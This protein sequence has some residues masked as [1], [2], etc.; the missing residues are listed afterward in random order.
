MRK[1]VKFSPPGTTF[2]AEVALLECKTGRDG[3]GRQMVHNYDEMFFFREQVESRERRRNDA[4]YTTKGHV[5]KVA[6]STMTT[7]RRDSPTCNTRL[8]K[9]VIRNIDVSISRSRSTLQFTKD[10]F[11]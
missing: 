7:P 3:R 1:V 10:N 2:K 8:G 6:L 5:T 4:Q 9:G 11:N